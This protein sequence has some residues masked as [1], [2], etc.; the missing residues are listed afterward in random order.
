MGGETRSGKARSKRAAVPNN[1]AVRKQLAKV[2]SDAKPGQTYATRKAARLEKAAGMR[3][4]VHLFHGGRRR[5]RRGGRRLRRLRSRRSCVVPRAYDIGPSVSSSTSYSSSASS[6]CSSN[7][8]TSSSLIR[9]R[10]AAAARF[11]LGAL[12]ASQGV[13]ALHLLGGGG[14]AAAGVGPV[15]ST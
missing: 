6:S 8:S 5:R 14:G 1:T 15:G 10:R 9:P 11:G 2:A 13:A 3:T 7:F 12:A 4:P